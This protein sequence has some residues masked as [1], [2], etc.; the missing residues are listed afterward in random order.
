[1][2]SWVLSY[3]Q[4]YHTPQGTVRFCYEVVLAP[5]V[6]HTVRTQIHDLQTPQSLRMR[7]ME[8]SLHFCCKHS[9]MY[10]FRRM[11]T[12]FQRLWCAILHHFYPSCE[13]RFFLCNDHDGSTLLVVHAA[14]LFLVHK[15]HSL[16]L[17]IRSGLG[18][19]GGTPFPGPTSNNYY[20]GQG[21]SLRC[22][23]KSH[24]SHSWSLLGN[25]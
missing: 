22:H 20:F 24:C 21:A 1:M 17:R 4:T 18:W 19:G 15:I 7:V 12:L 2:L 13:L 25:N 10:W 6:G 16:A 9:I 23:N 11:R 14:M 3:I 8:R 5:R